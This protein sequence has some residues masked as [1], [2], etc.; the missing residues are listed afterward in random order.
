MRTENWV[1]PPLHSVPLLSSET[2]HGLKMTIEQKKRPILFNAEMVRA[3]LSDLKT[4]T[5]RVI[6]PQPI[7]HPEW[8]EGTGFEWGK[9]TW[10]ICNFESVKEYFLARCPYG[11]IGDIL[12]LRE[13]WLQAETMDGFTTHYR[14][15]EPEMAGPWRPSIFMPRFRSRVT[16]E[17]TDVRVERVQDISPKDC[18]AEG[19][20]PDY[21]FGYGDMHGYLKSAFSVLWDSINAKPKP[22]YRKNKVGQKIIHHYVS[23]PWEDIKKTKEHRGKP[24]HIYGN[25]LIWAIGFQKR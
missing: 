7:Y 2:T 13:T 3:I 25:P 16:L 5:R 10:P 24:W 20:K 21:F 17:I 6:K 22:V 4:Q 18:S 23:Y 15:T 14:A 19:I 12:W 8:W 1:E 9:C 11:K